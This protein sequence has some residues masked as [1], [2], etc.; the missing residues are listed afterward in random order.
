MDEVMH[1]YVAEVKMRQQS[2]KYNFRVLNTYFK[3]FFDSD[4]LVLLDGVPVFDLNRLMALDPLKIKKMEIMYRKYY[5]GGL[6]ADGIV[7]Y[8]TYD[9]DLGGYTLDPNAV[10]VEYDGLQREREFYAPVYETDAQTNSRLPDCRNALHWAPRVKTGAD[11]RQQLSFYT[12]DLKGRFAVVIQG[13]TAA[14]LAGSK[15]FEFEVR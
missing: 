8:K 9:G 2:G 7:H 12:G 10:V 1:E 15:L 6:S 4:P 5:L 13:V 11:G 14:G 3:A